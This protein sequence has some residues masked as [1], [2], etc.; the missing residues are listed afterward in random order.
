ML[1]ELGH[2]WLL[3]NLSEAVQSE[4]LALNDLSSRGDSAEPWHRRSAEQ[5]AENIAWG[6]L[7]QPIRL[8]RIGDPPCEKVAAGF[9]LLTGSVSPHRCGG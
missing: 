1:H 9:E 8:L 3:D 2:A 4:F 5:A 6:L 7:E